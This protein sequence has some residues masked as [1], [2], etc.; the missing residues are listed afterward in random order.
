MIFL[1]PHFLNSLR[2]LNCVSERMGCKK[3]LP[4][5]SPDW[6]LSGTAPGGKQTMQCTRA[7]HRGQ[8]C[9]HESRFS[10][11]PLLIIV[12]FLLPWNQNCLKRLLTEWDDFILGINSPDRQYDN[13][14]QKIISTSS[15]EA[16]RERSFSRQKRIMGHSRV[17]SSADLLR[18]RFLFKGRAM[19]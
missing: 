10:S 17:R 18:S 19:E 4:C 13:I 6:E 11:T 9:V 8:Q 7:N 1:S 2:N 3:G 14:I 16:S 12:N 5:P 15:S